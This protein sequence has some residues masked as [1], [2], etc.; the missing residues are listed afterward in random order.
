MEGVEGHAAAS[1]AQ[2]QDADGDGDG[3][4]AVYNSL[5]NFHVARQ[6][7]SGQFSSVFKAVCTA[8]PSR[9]C[10]A[11]KKVKIFEMMD[12]KARADCIKEIELL[13]QCTHRNI[14]TY[15]GS[16]IEE[17][18]LNI[19]LEFAA[20]GDLTRILTHYK[21]HRRL[22]QEQMIWKYFVQLCAAV[23]HMH[24][25]R[26]MHRDI[27][28]ANVFITANGVVKLG[29]LGLGRFLSSGTNVANSVCGTPYYMAPERVAED[30]YSFLSD[31][32]SLGCVLYE[33]GALQS[34]FYEEGLSLYTLCQKIRACAYPALPPTLYSSELQDLAS[35]CIVVDP[36]Q[37][38]NAAQV[39]E[40]A[41]QMHARHCPGKQPCATAAAAAA[42]SNQSGVQHRPLAAAVPPRR[43]DVNAV[44]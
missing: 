20:A 19:V 42:A 39:Y 4:A 17:N 9:P 33:M 29:D 18:V 28:P 38:L 13:R 10:V 36:A 30:R 14:I 21:K 26:I 24:S 41:Q 32:W 1:H 15:L 2:V 44:R 23:D 11:L 31:V 5:A 40:V 16:F 12:A 8:H 3:D 25:R 22:I 37:R 35:G 27:K 7:G 6:V 43:S 34:P